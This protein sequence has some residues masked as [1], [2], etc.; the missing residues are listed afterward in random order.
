LTA[1]ACIVV[2]ALTVSLRFLATVSYSNDEYV[3]LAGAQQILFGEWPTRDFLDT[4]APLMYVAAAAAQRVFGPHLFAETMLTTGA[5]GLAAALTLLAVKRLSGSLAIGV[6]AAMLEIAFF[7]RGYAYPKVLLYAALPL[8]MW[9]YQRRPASWARML[10]LAAFVQLGFLL[11]HDHG[12]FLGVTAAVA[13][14]LGAGAPGSNVTRESIQRLVRFGLLLVLTAA[15]Y[16]AYIGVNGGIVRYFSRGLS[17]R[18]AEASGNQ[19]FIPPFGPGLTADENFEAF[20]FFLFYLLPVIA[21]IVLFV[22]ARRGG[23][24][25]VVARVAP[26]IVMAVLINRSFLRDELSTRLVDACVPAALLFAW[27]WHEITSIE[28]DRLR[29]VSLVA[30][31]VVAS[32]SAMAVAQIGRVPEQ[33]DRASLF[34]GLSRLPERFGE[35]SD[36]LRERFNARQMPSRAVLALVPFFQYVDRCTTVEHR[37]LLLGLIPEVGV[38]AERLVAGGRLSILPFY[39]DGPDERRELQDRLERQTVP[40]ALVTPNDKEAVW[41]AYPELATLVRDE[42]RPLV[43]YYS[44][45]TEQPAVEVFVSRTLAPRGIDSTTG[46]P[47]FR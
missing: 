47:C 1:V 42:Y 46:W 20:L 8:I 34:G 11:R 27:S 14:A 21:A 44:V 26:L 32:I 18:A 6:G 35:R 24:G 33:L 38:Y 40:F 5:F 7:P 31:V 4:G 28:S 25:S 13:V 2:F 16:L 45:D 37:L 10:A 19:L 30:A 43:N 12:L 36:E 29:W 15:P 39:N 17:A 22:R 3:S 41:A 9:W 23:A